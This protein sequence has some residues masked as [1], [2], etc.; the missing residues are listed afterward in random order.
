MQEHANLSVAHLLADRL[1]RRLALRLV[2]RVDV[3]E[4]RL[5]PHRFD[6]ALQIR[7]VSQPRA[8]IQVHPD[9]VHPTLGERERHALTEPAGCSEDQGPPIEG[10]SVFVAVAHGARRYFAR[11]SAASSSPSATSTDATRDV[12]AILASCAAAS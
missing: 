5:A 1:D 9:D 10:E 7:H 11:R 8:S 2:G 4:L 12:A 3:E 6:L